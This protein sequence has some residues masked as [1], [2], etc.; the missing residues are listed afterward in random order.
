MTGVAAQFATQCGWCYTIIYVGI[1]FFYSGNSTY[2][3][4]RHRHW[5]TL[6]SV[7]NYSMS[8]FVSQQI[9]KNMNYCRR[10]LPINDIA[11]IWKIAKTFLGDIC[12]LFV[13]GNCVSVEMN[14]KYPLC[15]SGLE[16]QVGKNYYIFIQFGTIILPFL[17]AYSALEA[18]LGAPI[19]NWRKQNAMDT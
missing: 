5:N 10:C 8:K 4:V 15:S 13:A 1:T 6:F 11:T 3:F 7:S 19:K 12:H 14:D 17:L 16:L 9:F 2:P 18:L